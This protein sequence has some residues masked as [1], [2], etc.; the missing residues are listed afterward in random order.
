MA[1]T[2]LRRLTGPCFSARVWFMGP[3]K[4]GRPKY[5]PRCTISFGWCYTG[6]V[7]RR[8]AESTMACRIATSASCAPSPLK[9]LIICWSPACYRG[10]CR[11]GS[12][13]HSECNIYPRLKTTPFTTGG[14]HQESRCRRSKG[15]DL[16]RLYSSL[17]GCFGR[18]E[19]HGPSGGKL[20]R[21]ISSCS[22][23][24]RRRC[25]GFTLDLN[26]SHR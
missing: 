19:M 9:P 17:A 8:R 3:R 12:F 6:G 21:Q 25:S 26:S 23:S 11:T 1:P 15:E 13:G 20:D 2:R 24:R 18:R 14:W 7:G 4:S 16:M 5:L 10:R 22:R